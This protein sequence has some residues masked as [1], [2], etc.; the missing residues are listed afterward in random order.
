MYKRHRRQVVIDQSVNITKMSPCHAAIDTIR[1]DPPSNEKMRE[2]RFSHLTTIPRA[3]AR[4]CVRDRPDLR[5]PAAARARAC[6]PRARR[7]LP[8]PEIFVEQCAVD[9]AQPNAGRWQAGR[10]RTGDYR[11]RCKTDEIL[12]TG[13]IA[14]RRREV[15]SRS[16]LCGARQESQGVHHLY[17]TGA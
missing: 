12:T 15:K 8:R 11:W 3:C 17:R 2:R 14:R 7:G 5:P 13:P 10:T 4:A 16:F 6:A 9:P 1:A